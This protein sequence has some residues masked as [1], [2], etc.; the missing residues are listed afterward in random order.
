MY[1]IGQSILTVDILQQFKDVVLAKL[2]GDVKWSVTLGWRGR[3]FSI[4]K[5]QYKPLNNHP[6]AKLLTVHFIEIT[7]PLDVI[8]SIKCIHGKKNEN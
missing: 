6:Q 2:H 3:E 7:R 4:T 1:P 8:A 5:I